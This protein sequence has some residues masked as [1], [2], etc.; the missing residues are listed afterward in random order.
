M[1]EHFNKQ[2]KIFN[3]LYDKYGFKHPLYYSLNYHDDLFIMS[4]M[5]LWC[6]YIQIMW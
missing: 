5:D 2:D 4:Y 3:G 1:K 6:V